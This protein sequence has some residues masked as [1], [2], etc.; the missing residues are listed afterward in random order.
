MDKSND[1]T[2]KLQTYVICEVNI[3]LLVTNNP[4][5]VK[6]SKLDYTV[7]LEQQAKQLLHETSSIKMLHRSVSTKDF[8]IWILKLF[9]NCLSE[10]LLSTFIDQLNDQ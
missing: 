3:S 5:T 2:L 8:K 6:E 7:L 4:I 10:L 9:S 1:A